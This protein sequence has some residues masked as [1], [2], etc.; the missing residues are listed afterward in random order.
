M[1]IYNLNFLTESRSVARIESYLRDVFVPMVC[2]TSEMPVPR[3][4]IV[5]KMQGQPVRNSDPVSLTLQFEFPT[6]E[7]A[8]KWL[9]NVAQGAIDAYSAEFGTEALVFHSLIEELPL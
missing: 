4:C 5:R 7:S 8:Q 2:V 6:E 1:Y 9:D 3:L